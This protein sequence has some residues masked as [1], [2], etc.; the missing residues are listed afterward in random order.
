MGPEDSRGRSLREFDLQTRLFKYPCSY[1]IHSESYRGLPESIREY[2]ENRLAQIVS[3][4]DD[5]GDFSYLDKPTR[6]AIGEILSETLEG[7]DARLDN[8]I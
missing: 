1:L 5:S 4:Q 2:V 8:A 7:F 6:V 3:G